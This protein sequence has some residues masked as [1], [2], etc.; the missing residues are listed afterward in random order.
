MINY[1]EKLKMAD[2]LLKECNSFLPEESS[3]V[4]K[5]INDINLIGDIIVEAGA[6]IQKETG[7]SPLKCAEYATTVCFFNSKRVALLKAVNKRK[8]E[9]RLKWLKEA[10]DS[11]KVVIE[12]EAK[13]EV[14]SYLAEEEFKANARE[15]SKSPQQCYKESMEQF[16]YAIKKDKKS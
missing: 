4:N 12:G 10:L 16:M 2:D 6:E 9:L 3:E 7:E 11:G 15:A 5:K 8:K 1:K 13:Q 14:K